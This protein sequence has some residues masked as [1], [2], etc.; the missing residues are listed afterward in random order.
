MVTPAPFPLLVLEEV[1]AV[2]AIEEGVEMYLEPPEAWT[3]D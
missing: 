2:E 3:H 1:E